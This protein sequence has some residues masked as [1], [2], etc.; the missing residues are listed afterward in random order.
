MVVIYERNPPA[1]SYGG[2]KYPYYTRKVR[3]INTKGKD[4]TRYMRVE[5]DDHNEYK[6]KIMK[7]ATNVNS[8]DRAYEEIKEH[9]KKTRAKY[10]AKKQGKQEAPPPNPP[11]KRRKKRK[12]RRIHHPDG[13]IEKQIIRHG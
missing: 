7:N 3:Y 9:N 12:I 4:M 13:T 2:K 11:Q 5:D 6:A 1:K 10:I 8:K